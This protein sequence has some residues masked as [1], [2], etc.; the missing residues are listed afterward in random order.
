M[1]DPL[2]ASDHNRKHR[3]AGPPGAAR[4][5]RRRRLADA[6]QVEAIETALG[7]V[8]GDP[9]K[10]AVDHGRDA[11]DGQRRLGDICRQDDLRLRTGTQRPVLIFGRQRAV[12]R[13]HES[14]VSRG[15][16]LDRRLN[17]A[18]LGHPRQKHEDMA[19]RGPIRENLP[20]QRFDCLGTGRTDRRVIGRSIGKV[21]PS[22][23]TT[24]QSSRNCATGWA[25]SV[26]DITTMMRSGRTSR[27]ISRRSARARSECRLLMELVEHHG[28]DGLEEGIGQQLPVE[29]ALSLVRSLVVAEIRRSNRIW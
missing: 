14:P 8:V 12:Q 23:R 25:S 20:D 5:L 15:Q 6:G 2:L 7:V 11:V 17:P 29:N 16:G 26:A 22:T 28:A 27:R 18:N 13:Q 3:L 1:A 21:R 4:P 19:G 24:G 10:A 9:G